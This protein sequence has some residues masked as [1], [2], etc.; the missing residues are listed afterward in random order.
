MS[1]NDTNAS[2]YLAFLLSYQTQ[3]TLDI[4]NVLLGWL[5]ESKEGNNTKA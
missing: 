3:H 4:L 1:P 5:Q 2:V